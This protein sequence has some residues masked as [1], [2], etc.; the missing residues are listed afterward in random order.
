MAA[1]RLADDVPF[2]VKRRRN[3]ELL[4]VQNRISEEDNQRFLGQTVLVLVEGPSKKAGSAAANVHPVQ[5]TGRTHCDR[6]V[7]FDGPHHLVGQTIGIGIYDITAHT[8][9]GT[10]MKPVPSVL[11]LAG[12]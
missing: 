7:V 8:L 9:L 4:A 6:I 10:V 2:E 11:P 1:R 12:N 5:L 3:N